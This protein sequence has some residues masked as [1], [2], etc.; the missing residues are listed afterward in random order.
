MPS[1]SSERNS[2]LV[3]LRV[4]AFLFDALLLAL[5]L[6]LPATVISW[7]VVVASGST[8]AVTLVWYGTLLAL[9]TLLL[10]RDGFRGRS[11]GKLILGLELHTPGG[12]PCGWL[13]S[14]VRNLPLIIPLWNLIEVYL[15]IFGSG[16]RTGDRLARTLV[17]EE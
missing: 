15:V 1:K 6:I 14:L 16:R 17:S 10:L 2:Q 13:R 3:L 5:A 4:A 7:I 8:K 12:V 9:L 11:L